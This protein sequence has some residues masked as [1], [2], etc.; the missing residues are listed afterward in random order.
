MKAIP[1]SFFTPSL[2]YSSISRSLI[3]LLWG[4]FGAFPYIYTRIGG[5][6]AE[7]TLYFL[8]FI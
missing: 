1:P 7:C 4:N 2:K 8:Y 5:L 6:D 3:F